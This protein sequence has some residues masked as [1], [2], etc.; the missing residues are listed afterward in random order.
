[1]VADDVNSKHF[2]KK[3]SKVDFTDVLEKIIYHQD[4]PISD[5]VCIPI[6]YL[7]KLATDKKVKV[8]QVGEGADEIFFLVI[9]IG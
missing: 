1:M 4:E 8:C 3:L 6:Y 5:P 9:P 7:S 2:E